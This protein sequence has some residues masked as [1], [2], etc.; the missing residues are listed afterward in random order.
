MLDRYSPRFQLT[1][2]SIC[3][4]ENCISN[5]RGSTRILRGSMNSEF[6]FQSQIR[7]RSGIAFSTRELQTAFRISNRY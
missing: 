5:P 2:D 3:F 7:Q 1:S 6:R 4:K